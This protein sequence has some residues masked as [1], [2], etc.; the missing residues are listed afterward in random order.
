MR[1]TKIAL[2]TDSSCDLSEEFIQEHNIYLLPL[3]IIY[4]GKEYKDRI[5][6]K[7]EEV[8][9]RMPEEVPFTSMPSAGEVIEILEELRRKG[10]GEVLA[11]LISSGLSSTHD[12]FKAIAQ[13]IENLKVEVFDSLSLSIGLGF[14]VSEAAEQIKK[15]CSLREVVEHLKKARDR[16]E[17]YYVIPTLQYLRRGGRIGFVEG[18]VGELLNIKP[19][20]SVNQEGKYFTFA[21]ARGRRASLQKL[22]ETARE[23]IGNKLV[24]LAVMHGGASQE[25]EEIMSQLKSLLPRLRKTVFGQISPALGVHT[26]PGLVGV[27]FYEVA[28][29]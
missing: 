14:L 26:G 3:K 15:N 19:I 29:E 6:I 16:I 20:I 22:V 5:E 23:R 9:A 8:Y 1:M 12:I 27:A 7:P 2:V 25:A 13:Q 11:V 28:P 24:D 18:T 10:F 21:K 4:P 17:V